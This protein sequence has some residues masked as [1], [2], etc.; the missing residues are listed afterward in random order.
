VFVGRRAELIEIVACWDRATGGEP[1]IVC[2]EGPAG[3]GKSLLIQAFLAGTAPAAVVTAS[4]DDDGEPTRVSALRSGLLLTAPTPVCGGTW[5]LGGGPTATIA[6][7][8]ACDL[9]GPR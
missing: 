4:G 1:G 2:V 7:Y 5:G 8:A 9:G 6:R 3:I